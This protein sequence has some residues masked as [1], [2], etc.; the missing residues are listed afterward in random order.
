MGSTL[1]R[2]FE[3]AYFTASCDSVETNTRFAKELKLDYPIL[4]DPDGKVA[5][6]F[7]VIRNLAIKFPARKTFYI[8][9]D[10]RIL[11][12]DQKVNVTRHAEDVV[13]RLKKL[14]IKQKDNS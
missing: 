4:S 9:V 5:L 8:G 12:I 2:D 13:D 7:G 1:L 11:Y 10:G 6:A 3:I 14:G